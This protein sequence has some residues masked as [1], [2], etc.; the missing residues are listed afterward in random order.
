MRCHGLSL[1]S[2]GDPGR[3]GR[4]GP[5]GPAGDPGPKVRFHNYRDY[6][7]ISNNLFYNVLSDTI[8]RERVEVP[9]HLEFL[10]RKDLLYV[11]VLIMVIIVILT[12]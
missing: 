5:L 10:A 1:S 3:S 2:Q 6:T 4:P 7:N 8:Y 9:D 11:F 12:L